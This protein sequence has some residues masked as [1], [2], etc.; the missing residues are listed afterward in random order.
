MNSKKRITGLVII[1]IISSSILIVTEAHSAIESKIQITKRNN[2]NLRD[3][4]FTQKLRHTIAKDRTLSE[5]ARNIKIITVRNHLT[6]SG[7]VSSKEE[8]NKIENLTKLITK[9]KTIY[10]ILTY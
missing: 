6:L 10:N 1:A 5:E 3:L 4:E 8:K 7:K 2:D 9:E